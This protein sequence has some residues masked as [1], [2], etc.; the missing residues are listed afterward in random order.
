MGVP[1]QEI[2]FLKADIGDLNFLPFPNRCELFI[3]VDVVDMPTL[4]GRFMFYPV[5]SQ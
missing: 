4:K 2:E 3:Q 5:I 1:N